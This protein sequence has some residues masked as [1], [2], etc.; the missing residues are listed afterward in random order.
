MTEQ[1]SNIAVTGASGY[2]GTGLIRRLEREDWIKN[3]LAIDIRPLST[4]PSPKVTYVKRSVTSPMSDL[5]EEH[6][7]DVVVHLAFVLEPGHNEEAIRKVNVEGTRQVLKSAATANIRQLIYFGSTTVYGA[8]PDNPP[9]LTEEA[10]VRPVEGFQYGRDKALTEKVFRE[11]AE[12]HPEIKAVILRGCPVLGPSADNFISR[13]FSK[14]ILVALKGFDPPMQLLHEEDLDEVMVH[15]IRHNVAGLYNVAG[16]GVVRWSEM[17][18]ILNRKVLKLP[19]ALLYGITEATWRLRLQ[20]ESPA[21]GLAFIQY[22]WTASTEKIRKDLGIK[23][24]HT[25]RDA[26]LA[27]ASRF[28]ATQTVA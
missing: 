7:I 26:W 15:C 19:P 12:G 23:F 18:R 6:R 10:P 5:F 1:A 4:P 3:I 27:F 28:S 2:I 22:P 13:A 9:N 8:H 21:A 16:D 20:S 11:F 17:G 25:S 24:K 14:P